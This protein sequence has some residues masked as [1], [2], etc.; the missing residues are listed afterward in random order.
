MVDKADSRNLFIAYTKDD[1]SIEITDEYDELNLYFEDWRKCVEVRNFHIE[2][3][4]KSQIEW[5]RD[6]IEKFLVE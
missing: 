1:N 5:E 2:A 4:R 3:K 6:R